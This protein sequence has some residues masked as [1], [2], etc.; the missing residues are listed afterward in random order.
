M[1][2]KN[3]LLFCEEH[4]KQLEL[5]GRVLYVKEVIKI[6]PQ[7]IVGYVW[8]RFKMV[9][10]NQQGC[11]FSRGSPACIFNYSQIETVYNT[12]LTLALCRQFLQIEVM[13]VWTENSKLKLLLCSI[14]A[15]GCAG[16]RAPVAG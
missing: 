9:Y 14:R 4:G 2:G 7:P 10:R 8:D 1:S 5:K 12:V 11:T 15:G 13:R 3:D 16:P 6:L